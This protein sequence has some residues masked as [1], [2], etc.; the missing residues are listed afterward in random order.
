[1]IWNSE[2]SLMIYHKFIT[3]IPKRKEKTGNFFFTKKGGILSLSTCAVNKRQNTN[4]SFLPVKQ[5]FRNFGMGIYSDLFFHSYPSIKLITDV[6]FGSITACI[7]FGLFSFLSWICQWNGSSS[8]SPLHLFCIW[9]L[10]YVKIDWA[11]A[12][13]IGH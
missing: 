6:H 12:R 8:R 9:H 4:Y 10:A 13:A 5:N 7:P 11:H 2:I 3:K 1:M